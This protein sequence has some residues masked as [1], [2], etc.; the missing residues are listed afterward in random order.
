MYILRCLMVHI[1]TTVG[2]IKLRLGLQ[3][4]LDLASPRPTLRVSFSVLR[5]SFSVPFHLH[6]WL[7]VS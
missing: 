6:V 3:V 4:G 2:W 1:M 7:Y 5:V